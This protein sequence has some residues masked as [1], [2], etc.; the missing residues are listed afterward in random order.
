MWVGDTACQQI[1]ESVQEET[2]NNGTLINIMQ[3]GE[4]YSK[5]LAVW[6]QETSSNVQYQL[7]RARTYYNKL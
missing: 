7:H 5:K 2:R 4:A 1:I 6:N 3:K